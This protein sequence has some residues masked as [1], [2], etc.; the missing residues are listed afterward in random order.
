MTFL[1]LSEKITF[2]QVIR[3]M[4]NMERSKDQDFHAI[5]SFTRHTR[6]LAR[7]GQ[8]KAIVP[9]DVRFGYPC[10]AGEGKEV[11]GQRHVCCSTHW[12]GESPISLAKARDRLAAF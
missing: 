3:S 4:V 11:C 5:A 10:F 8:R 12:L 9:P 2:V 7:Q 6:R 1:L